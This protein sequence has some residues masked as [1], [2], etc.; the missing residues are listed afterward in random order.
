MKN[1]IFIPKWLEVLRLIKN[2][3]DKDNLSQQLQSTY[4][5]ENNTYGIV[6]DL[7][8]FG[9]II[10]VPTSGRGNKAIIKDV[11]VI[12]FIQVYENLVYNKLQKDSLL[13]DN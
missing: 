7:E 2:N 3:Q 12:R 11:E 6:N 10:L 5:M 4:T 1:Y 13:G 8:K 9:F